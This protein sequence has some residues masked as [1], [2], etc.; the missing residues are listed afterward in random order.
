[1]KEDNLKGLF[2]KVSYD[3]PSNNLS[4]N[5]MEQVYKL[6]K[7]KVLIQIPKFNT[8]FIKFYF[9]ALIALIS[10]LTI[11]NYQNIEIVNH[12]T[13]SFMSNLFSNSSL[14]LIPIISI[15]IF[16]LLLIDR[17][18]SQKLRMRKG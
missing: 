18:I 8:V 13:F 15:S 16:I 6:E 4:M 11:L 5:I 17:K 2:K 12:N 7:K 9:A 1:M 3:E 14:G 10:I